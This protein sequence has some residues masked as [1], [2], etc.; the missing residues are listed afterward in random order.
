MA[1]V[2]GYFDD[3][4]DGKH[5]RFASI[6]GI[7]GHP[8]AWEIFDSRWSVATYDLPGPFHATDCDSNPPKGIFKG[9]TKDRADT[10]MASLVKI[11]PE[12]KLMCFGS[13]VPVP[14]YRKIFPGSKEDDPYLLA[15]RHMIVNMAMIGSEIAG[16][17][18]EADGVKIWCEDDRDTSAEAIRI[19]QA[20]KHLDGWEDG[21]YLKGFAV[22]S[23]ELNAIQGAD[24]IARE[25]F[26]HIDNL[27]LR[28]MR[29]PVR[30][31]RDS[32]TFHVWDE[33]CLAYLKANGGPTN[34]RLLTEWGYKK[35]PEVPEMPNFYRSSFGH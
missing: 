28:R 3:S 26:K 24:L 19:Y 10:L 29:R 15:V 21:K 5:E 4:G 27:G 23:K 33:A 31:L 34:L 20:L 17:F 8:R 14:L 25:A 6:G 30:K 16:S 1:V 11:I 7:I 35:P 2:R 9:W 13:I 32:A 22:A 12:A 18:A